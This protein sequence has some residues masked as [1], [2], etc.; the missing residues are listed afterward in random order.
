MKLPATTL[1][2]MI[3]TA[4]AQGHHDRLYRPSGKSVSEENTASKPASK[5]ISDGVTRPGKSRVSA[6]SWRATPAP[7]S[8]GPTMKSH[9]TAFAG[10]RRARNTPTVGN[11]KKDKAHSLSSGPV[12]S[13]E[14][15][16]N[17]NAI[18]QATMARIRSAHGKMATSLAFMVIPAPIHRQRRAAWS[19]RPPPPSRP[20]RLRCRPGR[21]RDP[22]NSSTTS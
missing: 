9:P 5:T 19:R 20:P 4:W 1:R 15:R 3:A 18:A 14:P 6:I 10:I 7:T 8:N 17:Q 13:S 12:T 21:G 16:S 22:A 11:A 2:T